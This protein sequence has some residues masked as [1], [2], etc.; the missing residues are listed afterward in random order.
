MDLPSDQVSGFY[1][2]ALESGILLSVAAE[3]LDAFSRN[4]A[5][6]K[7]LYQDVTGDR[8]CHILGLNLMF[9]L[10]EN[11]L[12]EFHA[13]LEQVSE[14]EARSAFISFPIELERQLMVGS[15]DE[16]LN[17][18]ARIPD[19][20]Y[21][22]FMKYLSQTVRDSIADCVEVSYDRM[23]V[24]DAM[25]MMNFESPKELR[26]YIEEFRDDWITEGETICFQA[27]PEGRMASDIRSMSLIEQSLSYATEMERIV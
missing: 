1:A 18:N 22:F 17:A 12:A 7:P 16:V 3:D 6:L 5:Q 26:E 2:N 15:Y 13:E 9:L 11:R 21:E 14:A 24:K 20:S 19:A 8:K 27:P 25:S 4:M 23:E 10:V